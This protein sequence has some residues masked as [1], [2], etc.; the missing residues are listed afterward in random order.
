[1]RN[2]LLLHL[3]SLLCCCLYSLN[4]PL[5]PLLYLRHE[6]GLLLLELLLFSVLQQ[7]RAATCKHPHLQLFAC[8]GGLVYS[9]SAQSRHVF[10]TQGTACPGQKQLPAVHGLPDA[11]AAMAFSILR[12]EAQQT[13]VEADLPSAAALLSAQP[14]CPAA[15]AGVP[16]VLMPAAVRAAPA[17]MLGTA[18]AC[19]PADCEPA[20][21]CC[22]R[23]RRS[24]S[25][26]LQSD[27]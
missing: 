23:G 8:H 18:A 6:G 7:P 27:A 20:A 21:P 1:M 13:F 3:D 14:L 4:L 25:Q 11:G 26:L 2:S 10:Q 5:T 9:C 12:C 22:S 17:H 15:A 16:P 24:M 19:Q